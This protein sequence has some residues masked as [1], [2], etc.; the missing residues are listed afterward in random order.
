MVGKRPFFRAATVCHHKNVREL[1][2]LG[3]FSENTPVLSDLIKFSFHLSFDDDDDDNDDDD[4][5]GEL[6][7]RY[8]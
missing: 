5:D 1:S 4:D 6:F 8:G 3:H 2:I 7:L